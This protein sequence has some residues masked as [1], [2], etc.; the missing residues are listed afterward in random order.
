MTITTKQATTILRIDKDLIFELCRENAAFLKTF[1]EYISDHTTMLSYKLKQHVNRT[2][3]ESLMIFLQYESKKQNTNRIKLRM[4][5]K[6]LAE[7][8]GVQRT[9]LSRELTKMK[10]DGIV[11]FDSESITVL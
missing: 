11:D 6:E 2:I 7:K 5:K 1:L 3:R 4:S 10:K 8:I 9:S